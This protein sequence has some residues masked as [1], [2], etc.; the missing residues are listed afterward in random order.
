MALLES[1]IAVTSD[2]PNELEK[3]MI[4][5]RLGPIPERL[6]DVSVFG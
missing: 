4:H 1:Y 3:K 5:G 2:M 6:V